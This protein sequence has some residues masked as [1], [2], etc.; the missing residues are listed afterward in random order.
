MIKQIIA[1]FSLLLFS[2]IG[3]AQIKKFDKK[4]GYFEYELVPMQQIVDSQNNHI[5][6]GIFRGVHTI[7]NKIIQSR[8]DA[9]IFMIKYDASN[10]I[11]WV[12]TFGSS[13]LKM[14]ASTSKASSLLKS[15]VDIAKQRMPGLK[16]AG[17]PL[18]AMSSKRLGYR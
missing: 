4:F 15:A 7:G 9:D 8:G 14:A 13:A 11:A 3:H 6:A 17:I 2:V 10:N 16:S 5:V 18:K 12:K 1:L